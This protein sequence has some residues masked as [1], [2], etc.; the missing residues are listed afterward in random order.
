MTSPTDAAVSVSPNVRYREQG[1]SMSKRLSAV[2]SL[3]FGCAVAPACTAQASDQFP[4][5]GRFAVTYTFATSTPA[6]PIDVGAGRDLTVNRYLVTTYNDA[7]AG[8]LHL[9]AG[10][11]V[12]IRFTI[13]DKRAIDTNA[14]CHFKDR[15]GDE[16][17]TSYTTGGQVPAKAITIT[18]TFISGT[19]KYDGIS[20]TAAATNSNN[21]DDQGAYQAAGKMTGSYK[22]VRPNMASEEGTH[23]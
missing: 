19:G 6:A 23:D 14:Y 8:F 16:L 3:T 4:S 18:W 21:L 2:L 17:F 10:Q 15:D 5:E 7:G 12:N 20:G 13:R 11:C 22:I 1:V 9:T